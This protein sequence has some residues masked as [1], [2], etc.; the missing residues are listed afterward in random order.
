LASKHRRQKKEE[1]KRGNCT[2]PFFLFPSLYDFEQGRKGKKRGKRKRE[3]PYSINHPISLEEEK[4]KGKK[5][6]EEGI[7]HLLSNYYHL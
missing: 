5:G 4:E 7:F 6:G 3:Y 1:K 2:P